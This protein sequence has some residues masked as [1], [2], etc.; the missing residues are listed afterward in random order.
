MLTK[1]HL[2]K[3]TVFPIVIYGC[4]SWTINKAEHQVLMLFNCGAWKGL[5]RVPCTARKTNQS[6]LKEIN[7]EY[8]W[9]D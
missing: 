5:L 8:F 3:A 7:P 4:E 6:I 9:K 2:A 1:V